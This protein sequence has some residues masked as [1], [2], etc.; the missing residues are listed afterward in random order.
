MLSPRLASRY[1]KSILN[2]AKERGVMDDVVKDMRLLEETLGASKD[3]RIMLKSP[4]IPS[5]KKEG[6]IQTLFADKLSEVTYKFIHLL[7]VKGREA[8]RS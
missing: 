5:D 3:L 7:V 8:T 1:A 4:V 6:V 2:L